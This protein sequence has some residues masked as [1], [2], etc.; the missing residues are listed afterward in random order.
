MSFLQNAKFKTGPGS[1]RL[2]HVVAFSIRECGEKCTKMEIEMDETN[3]KLIKVT[4][5]LEE[6]TKSQKDLDLFC[7]T[8]YAYGGGIKERRPNTC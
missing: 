5:T 1:L 6:K 7:K 3:E 2:P 8:H 4:A